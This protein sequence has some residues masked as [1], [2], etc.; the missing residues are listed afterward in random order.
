MTDLGALPVLG[1]RRARGRPP[2]R[3]RDS[4]RRLGVRPPAG[5]RCAPALDAP[6][7]G[8]TGAG[9]MP[10]RRPVGGCRIRSDRRHGRT[11]ARRHH[12]RRPRLATSSRTPT[13]AS[14][15]WARPSR[16]RQRLSQLLP[17]PGNLPPRTAQMVA[18]AEP[19]RVDPGPQRRRG[20]DARV[21]P[22]QA[23]P[24]PVQRPAGR[25]QE[26]PVPGRHRRRRV[27]PG[28]GDAGRAS[29]RAC[30]TS[31]PTPTPTPSARR[32]T[33]CCAR[34]R[35]APARTTSSTA[36]SGSAGRACC[37]TSRSAPGPASARSTRRP[38]TSW[39]PS[40]STFLDGD[41]DAIV[42]RAR[43][44]RCATAADGAR[45][46]AGGPAAR[47]AGQRCARPSSTSRWWASATRTST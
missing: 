10:D 2:R 32:S 16:L 38:T 6:S 37:S 31:G 24:A 13:A 14:S 11:S 30:A 17:E 36:T 12:P 33:C 46:R 44:A 1:P 45:V 26:L 8:D 42:E 15:T 35:S 23:A 25:R 34:S 19:G 4:A 39:S 5:P 7:A 41:T 22:H 20:A 40:C 29:A 27:A 3:R 47:P 21:Q 18:T 9:A 43:D 28:D